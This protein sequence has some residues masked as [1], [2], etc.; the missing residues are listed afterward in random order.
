MSDYII[1]PRKRAERIAAILIA[2]SVAVMGAAKPKAKARKVRKP[3]AVKAKNS[4]ASS[5][6]A[7]AK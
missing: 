7:L 5:V 2:A 6:A 4:P 1:L 3:R